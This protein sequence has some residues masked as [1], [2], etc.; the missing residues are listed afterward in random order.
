MPGSENTANREWKPQMTLSAYTGG[1]NIK[2][3]TPVLVISGGLILPGTIAQIGYSDD[4]PW[5]KIVVDDAIRQSLD[6]TKDPRVHPPV[7]PGCRFIY[8]PLPG[9]PGGVTGN[10]FCLIDEQQYQAL[11]AYHA[12]ATS[13]FVADPIISGEPPTH[14]EGPDPTK[15]P[16]PTTAPLTPPGE[17]PVAE[18]I[19]GD[20][21]EDGDVDERDAKIARK[22]ERK[23]QE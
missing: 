4:H 11:A 3:M 5:F 1:Y 21:D 12:K 6:V 20:I 9:E 7:L 22:R 13:G 23:N 2:I 14:Q 15:P 18:I 19:P 17:A 8:T 16:V 10:R